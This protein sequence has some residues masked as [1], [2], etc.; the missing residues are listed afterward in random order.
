MLTAL[1]IAQLLLRKI[2]EDAI[3]AFEAVDFLQDMKSFE[4]TSSAVLE[5]K[6]IE[7]ISENYE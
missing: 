5:E 7:I 3:M 2:G 6:I 4:G 1:S